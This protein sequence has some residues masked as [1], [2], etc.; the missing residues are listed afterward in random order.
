MF[1]LKLPAS[2]VSAVLLIATIVLSGCG[3]APQPATAVPPSPGAQPTDTTMPPTAAATEVPA[4]DMTGTLNVLEWAGYEQ[5]DFWVDFKNKYPKAS[6]NFEIGASD[7]DV[8]SKMKAGDQSDI[9]HAYSG[10][11]QFYVDN[12]LVE[13]LDTSKLTNW[14]KVPDSLKML[15]QI[16]A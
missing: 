13:E 15:G 3:P 4:A 9:F 8:F 11:L 12:G 1:R 16:N 5:S 6:V 14:D 7:A 10:W 2:S